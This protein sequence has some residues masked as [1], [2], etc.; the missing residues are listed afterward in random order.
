M[1]THNMHQAL[2]VGN[3]TLMMNAGR[4]V[5]DT[6]GEERSWSLYYTVQKGDTLSLLA[7]RYRTTE[8]EIMEKNHM[9]SKLLRLYTKIRL[10]R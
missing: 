6:S 5:F 4:I 3:R 8:E 9:T 7:R 1:V 10:P 2:D